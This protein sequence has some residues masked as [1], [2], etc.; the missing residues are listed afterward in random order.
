M[1]KEIFREMSDDSLKIQYD[2][3]CK[4]VLGNKIILAWIMKYTM[5]EFALFSVDEIVECI[6]G[7]P[8]IGTVGMNPGETNRKTPANEKVTGLAQEDK[9]P[10]EGSVTYD[11]R[12][13]AC[14]PKGKEKIKVIINVEAQTRFRPGYSLVTRG[15][16]YGARMLSAQQGR[17]F[18]APDYDS[19]KKVCSVWI[20]MAA[21][22]YIGNAVAKY[23][24]EKKDIV[25]GMPDIPKE[26]DKISVVM[27]CLNSKEWIDGAKR[28]NR[29]T[30][31]LNVLLSPEI[32][33]EAKVRIL[34]DDFE[35]VMEYGLE[36]E[37]R[38]MCNLSEYV[39]EKG[40]EKGIERGLE[41]LILDNLEERK[42]K[43]QI[44][45][46]LMKR[47]SLSRQDAEQYFERYAGVLSP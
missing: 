7:E 10:N 40:I 32:S 13:F 24:M 11:I 12:F 29:L 25:P 17:E 38:L 28:Q 19:I 3:Q 15:I 21:P 35:I 34:Q 47:L 44:I 14:Y 1:K 23:S 41:A 20:C 26:Y 37:M 42:N 18:V 2:A 43:E 6:E 5:K 4:R 9:I 8:E 27:V 31:L 36:K 30:E 46:K 16:Y 39:E 45:A 33:G 22:D